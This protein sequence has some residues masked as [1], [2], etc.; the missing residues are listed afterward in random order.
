MLVY[1]L[2][3]NGSL[4]KQLLSKEEGNKLPWASRFNIVKGVAAALL[5]LHEECEQKFVHR[6]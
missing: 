4:D 6:E 3:P 1:E 2:M 5:Y